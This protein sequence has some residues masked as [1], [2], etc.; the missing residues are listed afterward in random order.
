MVKVYS[1]NKWRLFVLL[2]VLV[3]I[4]FATQC[5]LNNVVDIVPSAEKFGYKQLALFQQLF[6]FSSGEFEPKTPLEKRIYVRSAFLVGDTEIRLTIIK[7][8]KN[9][10]PIYYKYGAMQS[11]VDVHCNLPK[12][13]DG[14]SP[15]CILVGHIG[16]KAIL[17]FYQKTSNAS[18][19]LID[20]SDLP[21]I[22]GDENANTYLYRLDVMTSIF[23]CMHRARYNVKYVAQTD[24]DEMVVLHNKEETLIELLDKLMNMYPDLAAVSFMSRRAQTPSNFDNRFMQKTTSFRDQYIPKLIRL[25]ERSLHAHIHHSLQNEKQPQSDKEYRV[26]DAGRRDAYILHMRR[27]DDNIY[28]NKRFEKTDILAGAAQQWNEAY[29]K[30]LNNYNFNIKEWNVNGLAALKNV[31]ECRKRHENNRIE[32]C[33]SIF[34]CS[35][36]LNT[37]QWF[38]APN[39]WYLL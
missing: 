36:N 14:Y 38:K 9:K 28:K 20:W 35:Q 31:E 27:V 6:D 33:H 8:Y 32:Q 17:E 30:R 23:D 21:P 29:K 34:D 5:G 13:I 26:I 16:V 3:F 37:S 2:F 15:T 4:G 22:Q 11:E 10:K 7:H 39:S 19:E 25:P 12:C 18:I 24:I 1:R